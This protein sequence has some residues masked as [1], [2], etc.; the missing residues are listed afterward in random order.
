ME[1]VVPDEQLSLAIGRKGQNV[2]LASKL[3]GWKID[4]KSETKYERSLKDGYQLLLKIPGLSESMADILYDAG[5]RSAEDILT[6]QIE[7]LDKIEGIDSE[8]VDG[9]VD[10][11]ALLVA[12]QD[13]EDQ[14]AEAQSSEEKEDG[15]PIE[16]SDEI[17]VGD[18]DAET[19]P[20]AE[21]TGLDAEPEKEPETGESEEADEEVSA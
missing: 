11:A 19:I 14:E 15:A 16:E 20:D 2:R 17:E 9:I 13:A 4:V 10:A 8:N 7:D 12:Q 3:S 5:Y 6:A 18:Q 21:T 1:V